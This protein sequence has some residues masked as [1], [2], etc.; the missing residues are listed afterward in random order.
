MNALTRWT[1][2][3][4][5]FRTP[6]DRLFHQAFNEFLAPAEAEQVSNRRFLPAADIRETT[7]ALTL[8]VELPGLTKDDVQ[9]TLENNILTLSGERKLEKDV[10]EE[11][12][13]RM[14][15]SY[16]TFIRT[17]ALPNNLQTEKVEAIFKDGV[18]N[19]SLPKAEETKPRKIEIR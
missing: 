13:H 2:A 6:F 8:H 4:E 1:A 17:F 5:V 14:E 16:G 18:L 7:E 15:R 12:Y 11:S 19:I 3:N 10:K 9:I